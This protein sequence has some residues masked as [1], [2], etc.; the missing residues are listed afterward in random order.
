M[1][2]RLPLLLLALLLAALLAACS[3]PAGP[4][5]GDERAAQSAV[6]LAFD[7]AFAASAALDDTD[8]ESQS[9]SGPSSQSAHPFVAVRR[10]EMRRSREALSLEVDF[11]ADPPT[12]TAVVALSVSGTAELWQVYPDRAAPRER[13]GEKPILMTGAVRVT[14]HK[15]EGQWQVVDVERSGLQQGPGAATVSAWS[16]SPDPLAAGSDENEASVT[17]SVQDADDDFLVLVRGRHLRVRGVLNDPLNDQGDAPDPVAGDGVYTGALEVPATARAGRHLA[18]VHA[19]NY[20]KTADLSEDESGG[21]LHPY[22]DTLLG[23]VV[24]IA[25]PD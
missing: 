24:R 17:L 13:V 23:V 25:E 1:I 6:L 11:Q 22:T 12:A 7:D 2:R 16:V 15:L 20:T 3:T 18:F 5:A 10:T 19:L 21:Y 9:L 8:L 4:L 14:A